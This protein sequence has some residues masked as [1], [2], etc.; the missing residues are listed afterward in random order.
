MNDER[1]ARLKAAITMID[2]A[3]GIVE[4]CA[5]EERTFY[6]EMPENLQSGEKGTKADEAATALE[7]AAPELE[8]IVAKIEE[9][10]A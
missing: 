8:E 9:A 4:E 5:T 6:D 2:E 3:R 10:M 1:R 7:E